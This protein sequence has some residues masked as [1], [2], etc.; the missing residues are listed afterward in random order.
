MEKCDRNVAIVAVFTHD[1][2]ASVLPNVS[3]IG[4]LRGGGVLANN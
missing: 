4:G 3:H 2:L 1:V